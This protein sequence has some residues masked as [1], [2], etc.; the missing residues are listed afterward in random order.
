MEE[1]C[2]NSEIEYALAL[3]LNIL[4]KEEL[5]QL[6]LIDFK[7]ALYHGKWHDQIPLHASEA[8]KDIFNISAEEVVITLTRLALT[9]GGYQGIDEYQDLLLG[10]KNQ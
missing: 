3:K 6:S 9:E 5:P 8:V 4:R 2:N 1:Q 10:G 7:Y